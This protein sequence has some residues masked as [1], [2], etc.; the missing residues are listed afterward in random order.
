MASALIWR[1]P[2]GQPVSC[3]EKIAVLN[4]NLVE[5]RQICQDAFE[6]ALLMGCDERQVRGVLAGLVAEL[7]NPFP[8]TSAAAAPSDSETHT[9]ANDTD[10]NDTG[11]RDS[12]DG[13]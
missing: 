6:D 10:A 4:E 9:G 12:G 7:V 1:R 8:A 2:D 11:A 3:V 13:A 5:I